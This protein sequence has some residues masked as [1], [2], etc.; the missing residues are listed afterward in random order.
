VTAIRGYARQAQLASMDR[1]LVSRIAELTVETDP[2]TAF[3]HLNC[4]AS[5]VPDD[6]STATA[7]IGLYHRL[8][9]PELAR[10]LEQRLTV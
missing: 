6:E 9:R 3:R 10:A 8:G 7:A 5:A 2:P 1:L 4:A